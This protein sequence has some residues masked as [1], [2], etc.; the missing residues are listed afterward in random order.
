MKHLK[1]FNES[2]TNQDITKISEAEF[3]DYLKGDTS[4]IDGHFIAKI[5]VLKFYSSHVYI[6]KTK[7]NFTDP[8]NFGVVSIDGVEI[9]MIESNGGLN[10]DRKKTLSIFKIGDSFICELSKH[11]WRG[12]WSL[13]LSKTK[14]YK[15]TEQGIID[16]ISEED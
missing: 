13:R 4:E 10:G 14:Y 7:I 8:I 16:F 2:Y 11:K 9:D 12:S 1:S 6:N 5:E 3:S 15:F